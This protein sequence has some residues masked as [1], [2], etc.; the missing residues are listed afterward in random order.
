M[1]ELVQRLSTGNHPVEVS[2]RP[3]R[4]ARALKDRIDD[5]GFVHIRFTETKGGTE[6]GVTLKMD[7]CNFA[8]ADFEAGH[9]KIRLAGSL[10]LNYVPVMCFADID[11]ST[12]SGTGHLKMA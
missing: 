9:G 6:L 5:Y 7:Q 2:L 1:D 4:V 3:E 8:S 12:L 10:S 11:L